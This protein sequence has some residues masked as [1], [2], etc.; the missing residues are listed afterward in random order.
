MISNIKIS[1]DHL[2]YYVRIGKAAKMLGVSI[3]TLR[4]WDKSGKLKA[5]RHLMSQYRLYKIKDIEK[6]LMSVAKTR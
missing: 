4:N 3:A 5:Y 6:L 2:S 1:D